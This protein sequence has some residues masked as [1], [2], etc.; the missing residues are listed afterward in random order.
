MKT[1][2]E[3]PETN[4]DVRPYETQLD[5]ANLFFN[6]AETNKLSTTV[7]TDKD[8]LV[9]FICGNAVSQDPVVVTKLAMLK[10]ILL[11]ITSIVTSFA[12]R[13]AEAYGQHHKTDINV[14]SMAFSKLVLMGPSK[15]DLKTYRRHT[16]H[17]KIETDI[18]AFVLDI[19]PEKGHELDRFKSFLERQGKT[20]KAA[21]PGDIG[22]YKTLTIGMA[23]E[24]FRVENEV[25]Y[26]PKI[27]LY[28]V[29]FTRNNTNWIGLCGADK[30]SIVS[31]EFDYSYADCVFDHKRLS[32]PGIGKSFDEY[33]NKMKQARIKDDS[34]FF[35]GDFGQVI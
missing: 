19:V 13:Y 9:L 29:N 25:V 12:A 24:V 34:A 8:G 26:I 15:V 21:I 35:N 6:T 2:K 30:P 3:I 27:K 33:I 28:Q 14:W 1:L 17:S 16:S 22:H 10:S 18:A 31:M 4:F 32:E 23:I 20:L 11:S 7:N 5:E